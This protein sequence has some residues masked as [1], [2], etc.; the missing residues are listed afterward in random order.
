MEEILVTCTSFILNRFGKKLDLSNI[1]SIKTNIKSDAEKIEKDISCQI[2]KFYKDLS[3][4]IDS[5]SIK[6]FIMLENK[7]I[8]S[9]DA[10]NNNINEENKMKKLNEKTVSHVASSYAGFFSLKVLTIGVIYL[11]LYIIFKDS[12]TLR[13]ILFIVIVILYIRYLINSFVFKAATGQIQLLKSIRESLTKHLFQSVQK[14]H[15]I[16][17]DLKSFA[18]DISP[19]VNPI[20][21][22]IMKENKTKLITDKHTHSN[23]CN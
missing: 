22:M 20:M 15:N 11:G 21:H 10:K 8:D 2:Y 12:P 13:L 7:Y 3:E 9:I 4:R 1:N 5:W 23:I 17:T 16:T 14:N 6:L 19:L 18:K